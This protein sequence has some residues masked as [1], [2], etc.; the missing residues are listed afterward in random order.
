[1]DNNDKIL[2]ELNYFFDEAIV[3]ITDESRVEIHKAA[4][5]NAIKKRLKKGESYVPQIPIYPNDEG[6]KDRNFLKESIEEILDYLVYQTSRYLCNQFYGAEM[7]SDADDDR[8]IESK[9]NELCLVKAIHLYA[10]ISN[11]H[12]LDKAYLLHKSN[13]EE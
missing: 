5:A 9:F 8:Y 10:L 3:P 13:L 2:K 4:F 11:Y 12:N 1:M 7:P 6:F